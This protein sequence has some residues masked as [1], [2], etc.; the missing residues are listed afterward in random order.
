MQTPGLLFFRLCRGSNRG[1]QFL[2]NAQLGG[3]LSL[4]GWVC[5]CVT[6][7]LALP[8]KP[9]SLDLNAAEPPRGLWE[10]CVNQE[11]VAT[12]GQAFE[13]LSLPRE[14]Q[15]CPILMVASRGLGL[16]GLLLSGFGSECCQFPRIRWGFKRRLCIL[17]RTVEA[18]VSAITLFPVSRVAH[19][20]IQDF[21]D[22]S[23]PEIVPQ[24]DFEDALY[25]GRAAGI[26]LALGGLLLVCLAFLGK[27][28]PS[29]QVAG[30]TAPNSAPAGEFDG[31]FY[32]IPRSRDL[33]I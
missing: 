33:F 9:P 19:A 27:D 23:I 11:E 28:V 1:P 5:S 4:L 8:R 14:F 16:L 30:P 24:K 6:T 31:P 13:F 12:V 17:G 25:L 15:V 21:S 3:L 20:T 10:V 7:T 32:L 22:D 29:L 2:C 26:F 18:K